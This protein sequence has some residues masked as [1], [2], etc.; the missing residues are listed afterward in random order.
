MRDFKGMEHLFDEAYS[1]RTDHR[2][3]AMGCFLDKDWL[4]LT[5]GMN[6]QYKVIGSQQPWWT[7]T[8]RVWIVCLYKAGI[9]EKAKAA[10][11]LKA[12]DQVAMDSGGASGEERIAPLLEEGMDLA[13]AVNYGRTLQEPM[14][15]LKMRDKLLDVIDDVLHLIETFQRVAGENLDTVMVGYT[16]LNHGQPMTFAHYL[17]GM[18]DGIYRGLLQLEQAYAFTNRNTGGCGSCSGITWEVDRA[19]QAELLGLDG[20][21]EPAYEG[22][23]AQDHTMAILFALTNICTLL[24]QNAMFMN[25]WAMDEIDMVRTPPSWCGCSSFMPQKCDSGSNY[26]RTRV[27]ASD[28]MG[29]TVKCL[30]Q[31]RGEPYADMQ[32]MFQLPDRAMHGILAARH[33]MQFFDHMLRNALIR[34][35]RMLQIARAGYSCATEVATHL[36]REKGYGG[37]LA[38]SIVATMVRQARVKGLK[39]Y[40]CTGRMLDEAAGYLSVPAPGLDDQTLRRLLDPEEFVQTHTHTGGTAPSENKRLLDARRQTLAEAR[41]RHAARRKQVDDAAAR[42]KREIAAICG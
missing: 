1:R 7:M 15:R 40:E 37:R 20:V 35:D 4:A 14:S 22:E 34:K 11:I 2:F 18:H 16:H 5:E 29:E 28:V 3:H 9:L 12:L 19:L 42:L 38:H 21:V 17:N 10:K 26:E 23:A 24:S 33:C 41:E 31:L 25:I 39:A 8:D 27:Y 36:I 30:F 6:A 13:S 32:G